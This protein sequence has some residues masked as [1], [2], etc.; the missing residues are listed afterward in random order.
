V[1]RQSTIPSLDGLIVRPWASH[2]APMGEPTLGDYLRGAD[3]FVHP[4][5]A[6]GN[7]NAV[8]E[9]MATGLPVIHAASGASVGFLTHGSDA[10]LFAPGEPPALRDTIESVLRDARLRAALAEA[11]RR[12]AEDF[13]LTSVVDRITGVYASLLDGG[14][15]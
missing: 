11:A 14:P 5:R 10:L 3:V 6:D 13:S 4:S 8:L 7:S 1:T 9:A 15:A 12:R 2:R